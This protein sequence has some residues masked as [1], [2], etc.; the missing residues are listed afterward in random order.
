MISFGVAFSMTNKENT[1]SNRFTLPVPETQPFI[2]IVA[3]PDRDYYDGDFGPEPGN[4]EQG[5]CGGCK[6]DVTSTAKRA[7]CPLCG[8]LC[9]KFL[10][11]ADCTP[12]LKER[13]TLERTLS[14]DALRRG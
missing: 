8:T 9:P 6:L 5:T 12:R 4:Y 2:E 13:L 14:E 3:W 7:F 11:T 10:T 1:R